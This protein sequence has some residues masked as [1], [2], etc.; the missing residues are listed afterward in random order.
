MALCVSA[1]KYARHGGVIR[2]RIRKYRVDDLIPVLIKIKDE[3]MKRR[4]PLP[5]GKEF[6]DMF[7]LSPTESQAIVAALE[8]KNYV[9]VLY[10]PKKL[11]GGQH[12]IW[13]ESDGLHLLSKRQSDMKMFWLNIAVS[14]I[15]ALITSLIV[16]ALS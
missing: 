2:L 10:D 9:R 15:T 12:Y 8:K 6:N 16:L 11:H 14:F 5:L 13:I 7:S 1:K 4:A 3:C